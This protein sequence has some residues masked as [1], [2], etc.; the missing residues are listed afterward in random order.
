MWVR[1]IDSAEYGEL[2]AQYS[3][4]YASST[5]FELPRIVSGEIS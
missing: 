1:D 5:R 2:L 4:R 3:L